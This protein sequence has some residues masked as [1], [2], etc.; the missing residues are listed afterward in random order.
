M[1]ATKDGSEMP[2]V[3]HFYSLLMKAGTKAQTSHLEAF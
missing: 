2:F 1:Q 3:P